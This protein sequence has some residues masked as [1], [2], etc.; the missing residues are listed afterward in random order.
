ML[1]RHYTPYDSPNDSYQSGT[2]RACKGREGG[3]GY[4]EEGGGDM[5]IGLVSEWAHASS[6]LVIRSQLSN[7]MTLA[8]KQD[9][10]D[11]LGRRH[12]VRLRLFC[13]VYQ[14][15]TQKFMPTEKTYYVLAAGVVGERVVATVTVRMV[16]NP[17]R[18]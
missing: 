15:K 1:N 5:S 11:A 4:T 18:V 7:S 10:T 8:N 2:Y 12:M 9:E 3:G 14:G 16:C 13:L 6:M 17:H